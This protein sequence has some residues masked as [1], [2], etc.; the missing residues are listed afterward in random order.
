MTEEQFV[1][2]VEKLTGTL[3]RVSRSI[4]SCDADCQD[5]VQAALFR[6]W[7]NIH[8][9]RDPDKFDCWLMRIVVNECRALYRRARPT[10]P[11]TEDLSDSGAQDGFWEIAHALDAKYR[12][13]AEL[14]YVEKYKT[15]EIA[16]IL[17][18]PEG[19]VRRRLH[20]ARTLLKE[21][22]ND[23]QTHS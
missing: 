16:Q 14:F 15:R 5:A 17:R 7:R 23:G 1:E 3:Y 20:T 10:Q 4:L 12:I 22:W 6:A 21:E 13:P 8:S 9:L 11:L 18:L 19:T 2:Q